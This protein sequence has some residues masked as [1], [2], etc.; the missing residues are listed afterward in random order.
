M[1]P[2]QIYAHSKKDTSV[3]KWQTLEDH[4]NNVGELAAVFAEPFES[5]EWGRILG[6]LHDVGK[7]RVSFQNYLRFSNGLLDSEYDA[8]DH[9]HSGAGA[10][11]VSANFSS[12]G[13]I[14]AYCI[15]GHHAGLPDWI[16][17]INPGGSLCH[18]LDVDKVVLQEQEVAEW[19]H[20]HQEAWR[21][22]HLLPPWKFE[23]EDASLWVR[24]L[25]S[26]LVDADF[27]DTEAF[28]T[29]ADSQH[30]SQHPSLSDLSVSF[31]RNLNH[32]QRNS[33]PTD[34]NKIRA[35]IRNA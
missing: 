31:F 27:I 5:A 22:T 2:E 7:S 19:I 11:W 25:F 8:S 34:V 1:V 32:K 9:S 20:G 35:E 21:K 24:M 15:A 3:S 30:R 10:V 28:L 17:G 23:P 12:C 4:L 13:R 16:G 33:A 29:P 6:A 26:C 14:L 18:R